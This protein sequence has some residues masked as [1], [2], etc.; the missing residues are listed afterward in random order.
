MSSMMRIM[1]VLPALHSGGVER[2]TIDL[3]KALTDAGHQ[4]LVVSSG[5]PMSEQVGLNGGEHIT[6]P[7]H[8]K[9][10]LVVWHNAARIAALASA[11]AIDLI[12][13]RSRAPAWSCLRASRLSG[14][15][16]LTTFHG[17]Y[18]HASRLKRLYNSAMLRG[19][20]CIAVSDFIAGHIRSVYPH[21]DNKLVTI[22]RG[23]D[24]TYFD[25]SSVSKE[26]VAALRNKWA[27]PEASE[28]V[29]TL[30]GRLTRLKGHSCFLEALQQ[31]GLESFTALIVGASEGREEYLKELDQKCRQLGLEKQVRF[32][33]P[34]DD[35]PALYALSDI[36]VS[37]S[38]KPEAFGRTNCEAQAMNTLV[39]ATDHGGSR[40]T[41]STEYGHQLC[42]PNDP[43][44]MAEALNAAATADH[45]EAIPSHDFIIE[46]YSLERMTSK[47]LSLYHELITSEQ[48]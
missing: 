22:H 15:P 38:S 11:K 46:N 20:A 42:A 12:H 17:Q 44:A 21:L 36:V 32:T 47:T 14:T 18:G 8:S 30:P 19:S 6:L 16:Y 13:V 7:V 39:V 29:I 45:H 24:T 10:P 4:A 48:H 25:P 33:G 31:S 35:M 23:I 26:R 37:A 3:V 41:L 1:Q 40:E 2:G 43:Q 34:C 28:L 5:G 27:L 9:N